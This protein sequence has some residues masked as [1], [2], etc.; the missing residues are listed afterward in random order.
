MIRTILIALSLTATPVAALTEDATKVCTGLGE[1]AEVV[2]MNRQAGIALSLALTVAPPEGGDTAP[3]VRA[4]IVGIISGA[5]DTPR[6][7]AR[8]NQR[9]AA[10][11]YRN[12][13]EAMCFKEAMQ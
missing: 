13:I 12:E 10:Q 6:F 3:E 7:S 5:Y 2:M 11:D 1:L 8:E 4:L 9:N